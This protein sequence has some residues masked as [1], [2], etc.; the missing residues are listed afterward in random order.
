MRLLFIASHGLR[1]IKHPDA[2]ARS[3]DNRTKTWNG[4]LALCPAVQT[5]ISVKNL[6]IKETNGGDKLVFCTSGRQLG[7]FSLSEKPESKDAAFNGGRAD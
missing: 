6:L 7:V 2:V 4:V 5:E 3:T 1:L